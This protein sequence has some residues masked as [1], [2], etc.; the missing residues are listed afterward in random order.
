MP[1]RLA[2]EA[3]GVALVD[4]DEGAVSVGQASQLVQ[5]RHVAVHGEDAVGDDQ[6][7]PRRPVD[8]LFQLRLQICVRTVPNYCYFSS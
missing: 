7:H 5:R 2:E 3:G 6:P 8:G 4:E 1:S